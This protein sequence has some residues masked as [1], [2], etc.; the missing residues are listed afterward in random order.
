MTKEVRDH[1]VVRKQNCQLA[2][3]ELTEEKDRKKRGGRERESQGESG[4]EWQ[5]GRRF[6]LPALV[7][8]AS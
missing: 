1:P 8:H 4:S 7:W 3:K 5:N 6:S 2:V